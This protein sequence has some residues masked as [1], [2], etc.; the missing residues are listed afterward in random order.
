MQQTIGA[1]PKD[2]VVAL[3][4]DAA[5]F[6]IV[7]LQDNVPFEEI[8]NESLVFVLPNPSGD[9]GFRAGTL[10]GCTP[11]YAN[12]MW[13]IGADDTTNEIVPEWFKYKYNIIPTVEEPRLWYSILVSSEAGDQVWE[14]DDG[15]EAEEYI[16]GLLRQQ[17]KFS[18]VV[19][20]A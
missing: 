8:T 4:N 19:S 11:K 16:E 10:F 9:N 13:L 12:F 2:E 1:V 15:F 20:K 7:Y 14:S 6:A 3:L 5:E 18:V 17:C